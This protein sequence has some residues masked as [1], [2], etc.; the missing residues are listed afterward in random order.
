MIGW[1]EVCPLLDYYTQLAFT[2][3]QITYDSIFLT[4][5]ALFC[6]DCGKISRCHRHLSGA[7]STQP[8]GDDL[9]GGTIY[10]YYISWYECGG[11][12]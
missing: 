9:N 5:A 7:Y 8:I 3:S 10:D 6:S 12:F 4:L 1:S 2:R 11:D